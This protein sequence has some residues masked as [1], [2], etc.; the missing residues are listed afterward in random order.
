MYNRSMRVLPSQL[1]SLSMLTQ[2]IFAGTMAYALFGEVPSPLLLPADLLVVCGAS[3]VTFDR[4][5][6]TAKLG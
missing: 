1:V 4:K 3:L 6:R 5:L 2:F